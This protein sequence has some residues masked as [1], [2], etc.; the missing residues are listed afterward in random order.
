MHAFRCYICAA[1]IACDSG[2]TCKSLYR[3]VAYSL[4]PVEK[5]SV[6]GSGKHCHEMPCAN[7]QWQ[8][9]LHCHVQPG[10]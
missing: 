4:P 9:D 7:G 8:V 2:P 5:V 1:R 3:E 6:N 10:Q